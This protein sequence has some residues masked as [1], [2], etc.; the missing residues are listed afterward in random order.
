MN[1]IDFAYKGKRIA[2]RGEHRDAIVTVDGREFPATVIMPTNN[3]PV[4]MCD[5]PGTGG[6]IAGFM[7][8]PDYNTVPQIES[9][10]GSAHVRVVAFVGNVPKGPRD[11]MFWLTHA[12]VA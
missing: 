12:D 2:I 3:I 11:P 7:A 9:P 8:S 5:F 4:W 1:D 10:H 6:T